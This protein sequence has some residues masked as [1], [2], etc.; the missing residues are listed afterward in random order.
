MIEEG[1]F[2]ALRMTVLTFAEDENRTTHRLLAAG[3]LGMTG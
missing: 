1:C 2:A 3:R